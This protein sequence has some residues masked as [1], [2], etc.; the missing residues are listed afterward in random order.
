MAD[1]H[2][3][4]HRM[5]NAHDLRALADLQVAVG[6]S[7]ARLERAAQD[8]ESDGRRRL[9]Q[10]LAEERARIGRDL[11]ATLKSLGGAPTTTTPPHGEGGSI[12]AKARRAVSDIGH[13]L[14]GETAETIDAA[15]DGETALIR[16]LDAALGD[17]QLSDVAR[18]AVRRA[19]AAVAGDRDD[20]HALRESLDN[21]RDAASPLFPY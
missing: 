9:F 21:R 8:S 11:G 18:A 14:L 10:A 17:P 3:V 6:D 13:A 4:T 2:G 5:T 12:L 1:D 19:R 15:D 16:R 20:L 7:G